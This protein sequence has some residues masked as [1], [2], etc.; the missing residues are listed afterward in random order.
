MSEMTN[1]HLKFFFD[2]CEE[3][4]LVVHSEGE[5]SMLIGGGESCAVNCTVICSTD[6]FQVQAMEGRQ[7]GKL[8]L[9]GI[10]SW[11][12]EGR[13]TIIV[14]FGK[15][16]AKDLLRRVSMQIGNGTSDGCHLQFHSLFDRS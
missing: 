3:R 6:G 16:N 5:D 14:V 8:E 4:A 2:V 13:V 7:H 11:N 1:G 9:D 10:A 12:L 15:F